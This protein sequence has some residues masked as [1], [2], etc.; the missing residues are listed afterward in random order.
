MAVTNTVL[1]NA[2]AMLNEKSNK[3]LR[4][5]NYGATKTFNKYKKEVILNYDEFN[6]V[7][8]QSDLQT[9]QIDYL[10]R[11]TQSVA[12]ARSHSLSAV[13]PASTRD[14]L[15]FVTYARV[16]SV[17][18]GQAANNTIKLAAQLANQITNARL[19]IG[20]DIETA[21]VAKLEAFKNTTKGTRSL[22]TWDS[23]VYVQEFAIANKTEYYNYIKS[24]MSELD[25][26]GIFQEV[27]TPNLESLR[28]YQ[29]AQGAGNSA[30]LVFQYPDFDVEVSGSI[31]NASDYFGTSYVVPA[32]SVALVDWIPEKNRRGMMGFAGAWDFDQI[33]DPFGIFDRMA[34]AK[35]ESVVDGSTAGGAQDAVHTYELSVDV[36]FYVPTITTGKLVNKFA[37]T[38]A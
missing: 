31:T 32:A 5:P 27:H 30:N 17:S 12:S 26:N 21:A 3:D 20:A 6:L 2:L 34:L 14:T 7:K 35:Y 22:G 36:A 8:N 23:G 28:W 1:L 37:L 13:Y 15:T 16:F 18:E 33:P 11:D 10:R 19:D 4:A 29:V 25:Y 24:S 9:K 38:L